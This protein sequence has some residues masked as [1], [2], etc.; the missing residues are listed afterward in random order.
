M[1][2]PLQAAASPDV[3]E[4]A[5]VACQHLRALAQED[6]VTPFAIAAVV[7]ACLSALSSPAVADELIRAI[8]RHL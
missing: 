8:S 7:S 6:G 3:I 5:L 4:A 2:L 1:P